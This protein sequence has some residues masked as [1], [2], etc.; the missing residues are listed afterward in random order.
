MDKN[1]TIKLK[2]QELIHGKG[3][4]VYELADKVNKSYSYLCRIASPTEELPTPIE[5]VLPAMKLKKNYT[6]LEYLAWECGFAL[7]RLPKVSIEK[8]DETE[9][10]AGYQKAVTTAISTLLQYLDQSTQENYNAVQQA[11]VDAVQRG[12]QVKKYCE[13]KHSK[14]LEFNI[15]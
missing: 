3:M 14:Q 13:K 1:T 6:L 5:V 15:D 2:V 12:L 10:V 9:L 7:V 8:K 4:T 11:L